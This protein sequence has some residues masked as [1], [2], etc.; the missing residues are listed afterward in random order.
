MLLRLGVGKI[1]H[2]ESDN[3]PREDNDPKVEDLM[4]VRSAQVAV[5]ERF[6]SCNRAE[7]QKVDLELF[8]ENQWWLPEEG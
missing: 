2:N 1:C 8:R 6:L 3:D 4:V 7:L 5:V